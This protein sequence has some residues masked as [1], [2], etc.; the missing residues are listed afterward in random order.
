MMH[1]H[2]NLKFIKSV[3]ELYVLECYNS[4]IS[5]GLFLKCFADIPEK[6]CDA[7]G[8]YVVLRNQSWGE[9]I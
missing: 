6:D 7:D 3:F 9:E 5:F 2:M 1:G 8:I 4:L